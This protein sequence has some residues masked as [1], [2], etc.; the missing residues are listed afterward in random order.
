MSDFGKARSCNKECGSMIYFDRNSLIGHPT[1][2]VWLPLEYK[3][4]RKTDTLHDCPK[5]KTNNTL[6]TYNGGNGGSKPTAKE[7]K[8]IPKIDLNNLNVVRVIAAA[9]NEYIAWKEAGQ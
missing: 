7:V 5:K 4:G 2:N 1:E 3:E 6:N 8:E 9:L